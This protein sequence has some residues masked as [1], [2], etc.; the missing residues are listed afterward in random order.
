[1]PDV[2][3][4]ETMEMPAT[5]MEMERSRW[6]APSARLGALAA[7]LGRRAEP[8]VAAA[9]STA[10]AAPQA[11]TEA[12]EAAF[13]SEGFLIIPG[14]L[15]ASRLAAMRG[16]VERR[17]EAEGEMGGW[18]GGHSGVARRLCNLATKDE[19]FAELGVEPLFL[20]G[21]QLAIGRDDFIFNAMNFHDPVPGQVA[22]QHIHADRG[23][24]PSCE[25]YFNVIVAL[26]DLTKENGCARVRAVAHD[27]PRFLA[28]AAMLCLYLCV[29]GRAVRSATRLLPGS[30][31]RP[32]PNQDPGNELIHIERAPLAD[33][34][35]DVPGQIFAEC[36]AGSAVFTHGD[37]WH[38]ACDNRSSGT[39]RVI[40]VGF[41]CPSTRPQYEIAGALP[42]STRERF[43]QLQQLAPFRNWWK[44]PATYKSGGT[45]T[46]E[47]PLPAPPAALEARVSASASKYQEPKFSLPGRP[48][49][50]RADE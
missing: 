17:V 13:L 12:Q 22:R 39:R 8:V 49:A 10:P 41:A 24:F 38:G 32:W 26:D 6:R 34:L 47:T 16:A 33:T 48:G 35:D 7:H 37:L 50:K 42:Q 3:P 40:H 25:G 43:P 46:S 15:S 28:H 27:P 30:H 11:L 9:A 1:M 20:Q 4:M 5:N 45:P 18:E 31:A 14:F 36:P 21:A 44:T 29:C 19:L 2:T 23:F